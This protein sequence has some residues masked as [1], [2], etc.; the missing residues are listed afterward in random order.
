MPSHLTCFLVPSFCSNARC[1]KE[2]GKRWTAGRSHHL[3]LVSWIG[4]SSVQTFRSNLIRKDYRGQSKQQDAQFLNGALASFGAAFLETG[5]PG[6]TRLG[7]SPQQAA[8]ANGWCQGQGMGCRAT[9]QGS[10]RRGAAMSKSGEA[11]P[12]RRQHKLFSLIPGTT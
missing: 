9:R 12:G 3:N 6:S 4:P 7:T 2:A 1:P 11:F 8:R 10:D 5:R